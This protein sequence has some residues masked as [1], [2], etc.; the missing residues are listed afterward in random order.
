MNRGEYLRSAKALLVDNFRSND[1]DG[2]M[3][4]ASAAYLLK[5]LL[6]NFEDFGFLKFKDLLFELENENFLVTGPNSK[7]AFSLRLLRSEGK[8]SLPQP[9]MHHKRLKTDVWYAFVKADPPGKRYFNSSSGEI[10]NEN[11]AS[12]GIGWIELT[13]VSSEWEKQNAISFLDKKNITS[14][15]ARNAIQASKWYL[16]FAESLCEISPQLANEWKRERSK[17]VIEVVQN[18]CESNGVDVSLVFENAAT[19]QK[20]IDNQVILHPVN[21]SQDQLRQVLLSSISKLTTAELL[22]IRIPASILIGELRPD[23]LK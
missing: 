20:R 10:L 2:S 18:W 11:D 5:R 12:P 16:A 9:S 6:G 17:A 19:I 4:A 7:N 22:E 8:A 3:T 1:P 23:L 13:P 21:R 15:S 14:E